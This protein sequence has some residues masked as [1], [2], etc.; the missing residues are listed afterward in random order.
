VVK[1][2]SKIVARWTNVAW[3]AHDMSL[4]SNLRFNSHIEVVVYG[5]DLI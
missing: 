1:E 3:V 5:N 4:N 2:E